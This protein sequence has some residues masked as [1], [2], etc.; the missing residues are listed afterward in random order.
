VEAQRK[1][2]LNAVTS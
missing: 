1:Y 2:N